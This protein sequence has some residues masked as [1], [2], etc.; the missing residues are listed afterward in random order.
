MSMNKRFGIIGFPLGH[1]FSKHYFEGFFAENKLDNYYFDN[2]ELKKISDIEQVFDEV[3]D[4]CGFSVTIPYKEQ[5]I[6]YLDNLDELAERVGAVNCVKVIKDGQSTRKIGYNTDVHGF[7]KSLDQFL[8]NAH[9]SALVLGSGGA[10]KAVCVGLEEM[11]ID[12]LVVS[13]TPKANE[14]SYK[15]VTKKLLNQYK[16]IINTT[17]L[18]MSPNID[19]KPDLPYKYIN[20]LYCAYD[21]VYNPAYTSF[22]DE[23]TKR[24]ARVKCGLDMLVYQAE[25]AWEIYNE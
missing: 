8:N 13:R 20:D 25:K 5:I 2:Y 17:P 4:L 1:S 3:T 24:G 14:I 6:P 19:D 15:D 7:M 18:G 16:L 10:S 12:Y 22:M 9:P 21:L 23:F 11:E